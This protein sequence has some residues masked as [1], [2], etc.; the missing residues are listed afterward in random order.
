MNEQNEPQM[1]STENS[2]ITNKLQNLTYLKDQKFI[3]D[4]HYLELYQRI[5]ENYTHLDRSIEKRC[6]WLYDY[7]FNKE[8]NSDFFNNE[9]KSYTIL[10]K[11]I[12][13]FC[14]SSY[15]ATNILQNLY[16]YNISIDNKICY[17]TEGTKYL[18][19][20]NIENIGSFFV[21]FP[22]N[23]YIEPE[24]EKNIKE[25]QQ[26]KFINQ[27]LI[28]NSSS[29]I[30][31]KQDEEEEN[32]SCFKQFCFE[33]NVNE[34]QTNLIK[35]QTK[36]GDNPNNPN[37]ISNVNPNDFEIN[38]NSQNNNNKLIVYQNGREKNPHV[39]V[40]ILNKIKEKPTNLIKGFDFS[41]QFLE[42]YNTNQELL[43]DDIL[44][45]E[46]EELFNDK[47]QY[48]LIKQEHNKYIFI[49]ELCGEIKEK[50][51][52]D[53]LSF[54]KYK[55]CFYIHLSFEINDEKPTD[56]YKKLKEPEY[57]NITVEDMKIEQ[58][59]ITITLKLR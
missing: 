19:L 20:K 22:I 37:P 14:T 44:K 9:K 58:G 7:E 32:D 42:Y 1:E 35:I 15:V 29:L 5:E 47:I 16:N 4:K 2:E 3:S 10:N 23:R 52:E 17:L 31:I 33:Y 13:I 45:C 34:N 43:K 25:V 27:F 49:I 53:Y 36:I 24:N 21:A 48:N 18:E 54:F 11:I 26:Q 38:N 12:T 59:F 8:I 6:N 41:S 39:F 28:E 55:D 46:H 56:I 30:Y 57:Q 40:H 51:K 50:Q